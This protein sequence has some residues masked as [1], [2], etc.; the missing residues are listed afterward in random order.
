MSVVLLHAANS[1]FSLLDK[2]KGEADIQI[3]EL[4]VAQQFFRFLLLA[5]TSYYDSGRQ[6]GRMRYVIV[7]SLTLHN[8]SHCSCSNMYQGIIVSLH[9]EAIAQEAKLCCRVIEHRTAITRIDH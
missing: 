2:L 3:G 5:W 8:K 9:V 7:N 4:L 6:K 1:I